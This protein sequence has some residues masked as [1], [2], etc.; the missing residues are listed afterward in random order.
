MFLV[1]GQDVEVLLNIRASNSDSNEDLFRISSYEA[2]RG[3][4]QQCSGSVKEDAVPQDRRKSPSAFH[5]DPKTEAML[6]AVTD[7]HNDASSDSASPNS[8]VTSSV[9]SDAGAGTATPQTPDC[10]GQ[11]CD[12]LD[13]S[14]LQAVAGSR[15]SIYKYVET[16][17]VAYPHAFQSLVEFTANET[18][19]AAHCC[20]CNTVSDMPLKHETPYKVQP[21]VL[22]TMLQLPLLSLGTRGK[23]GADVT[24]L[25]SAIRHV[26]VSSRWKK[27][28]NESFCAHSTVEP[29]SGTFMVD[30]F[31]SPGSEAA[32]I[33]MA[34]SELKAVPIAAPEPA[35]PR[36][37]AE[38]SLQV[39]A[40]QAA[41][42]QRRGQR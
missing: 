36:E 9:A 25:P 28:M 32:S 12:K 29:R 23:A 33:S 15:P 22:D 34:G 2:G 14:K 38:L 3:R 4:L 30:T 1:E 18:E 13:P 16:L 35:K 8:K 39:G 27:R 10:A 41:R 20:A 42:D 37:R 7:A 19:V 24:Y 5:L 31:S 26:T 11:M 21:S 17:G 40:G 6:R